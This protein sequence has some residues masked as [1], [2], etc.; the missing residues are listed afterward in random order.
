MA[1]AKKA[2]GGEGEQPAPKKKSKLLLIIIIAV[3]AVALIGGGAAFLLMGKK[4][5][6][7]EDEGEEAPAK[8]AKAKQEHSTEAA[9][10]F[11]PRRVT[12]SVTLPAASPTD[13]VGALNWTAPGPVAPDQPTWSTQAQSMPPETESSLIKAHFRACAPEA[14]AKTLCCQS[15]SPLMPPPC[16][17]PSM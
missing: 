9:P 11:P 4:K 3:V 17:M 5:A 10:V 7:A 1:E 15:M 16:S 12:V 14:S 2:E 13:E 8:E 6:P